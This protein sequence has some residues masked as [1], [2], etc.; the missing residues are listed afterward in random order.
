MDILKIRYKGLV[1][2][3]DMCHKGFQASNQA[4]FQVLTRFVNFAIISLLKPPV[5][6][7]RHGG[8]FI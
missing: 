5:L 8:V 7:A 3:D 1:L 6:T 2:C 4:F